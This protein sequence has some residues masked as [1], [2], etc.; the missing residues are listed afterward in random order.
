V[1]DPKS[2]QV[3]PKDQWYAAPAKPPERKEA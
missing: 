2:P 1:L 3:V